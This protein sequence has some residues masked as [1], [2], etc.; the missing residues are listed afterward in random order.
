MSDTDPY[1]GGRLIELRRADPESETDAADEGKPPAPPSPPP[2]AAGDGEPGKRH[3]IIPEPLQRANLRQT[4]KDFAGLQGYRAAYH[5]V[6]SWWYPLWFTWLA[7]RGGWKLTKRLVTWWAELGMKILESQAVAAGR[8]GHHDAMRAHAEGG[9]T[10]V[11]RG[12]IVGVTTAVLL[13][14]LLAMYRFAPR[15]SFGLLGVGLF[16]VLVYHGKPAGRPVIAPAILPPKYEVPTPEI[17]TRAF[18]SLGI[19]KISQHIKDKKTL[20]WVSDVH[21]D[22]PG[23]AVELDLPHGV[24][25]KTIIKKREELSSGLRRPLS[26][27]WPEGVPGEHE[28]RVF[29]WIGRQDMAKVKPPPYPFLKAGQTDIFQPVP[30]ALTPRGQ[31]VSVPL[32]QSNWLIGGAP[33]NGKT[34]AVRVLAAAAALDPVCDLWVHELLGKGDLESFGQ[35]C[36]RYCSGLDEESLEYAAESVQKLVA[37]VTR[38]TEILK[39]I[40]T[41]ARPDGAITRAIASDPRMR[42]RPIVAIFDEVHNLFLHKRLG[43]QAAEDLPHVIRSARALGIIIVAATQRPDKDSFPTTLSGI[44]TSRFCL[45]VPDWQANDMI[46]GTGAYQAGYN[47]V[48]FRQETDAGLGWMRGATEPQAVRTYY[49]NLPAAERI[50]ARARAIRQAAGVLSGYALGED[51]AES[52][53][54]FLSD[55]LAVFGTDEKLWCSTIA[56]R[57]GGRLGGVYEDITSAAV[58]SQLRETG[59]EVKNVREPGRKPNLGCEKA[60]VE[61]AAA[62]R[63]TAA[64]A[65]ESP[66]SVR[67]PEPPIDETLSDRVPTGPPPGDLPE[68]FPALL[69]QAAELVIATQFGSTSML[70]RKLRVGFALAGRLMDALESQEIVGPSKGSQARD[71]LFATDDLEAA[72]DR[73]REAA[74]V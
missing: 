54:S 37:E 9:K 67:V 21:R 59:V 15:W 8:A 40:P 72:L 14:G 34:G 62:G 25:A 65:P 2:V 35:V 17:I 27:V 73:V 1:E 56:T 45:K 42:F 32:F 53:R 36:Q 60:A 3:P 10:R 28:A 70:Q 49:L 12:K 4:L 38:R 44:V 16:P 74:G 68:D 63:P 13:A 57:L 61:A 71:V 26:A 23:W 47:A 11:A 52:G 7:V 46:L 39:K 41:S 51:G 29:L 19:P 43:P 64:A 24:T 58:S 30:Y 20:D 66:R 33:G 50:C 55:V 18:D 6:R 48:A 22:G 31:V 69:V 5:G